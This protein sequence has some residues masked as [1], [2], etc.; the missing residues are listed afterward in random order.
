MVVVPCLA[1]IVLCVV[2]ALWWLAESGELSDVLAAILEGN[3][4]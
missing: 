1:S 3:A 4:N 2:V